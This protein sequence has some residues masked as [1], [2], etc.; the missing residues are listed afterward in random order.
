MSA[1]SDA[2][3]SNP[4]LRPPSIRC[5]SL[6]VA[7]RQCTARAMRG[8]DLCYPHAKNRRLVL[9]RGVNVT[10]PLF[11]DLD[12]IRVFGTQMIQG[13]LTKAID[14]RR[15]GKI[16]YACQII[17]NTM[18]R[19]ARLAAT[20]EQEKIADPVTEVSEGPD[21]DLGP[22]EDSRTQA[23]FGDIWS[24]D[25]YRFEQECER[26]GRPLPK[27]PADLPQSGWLNPEDID[28]V[29]RQR[30]TGQRLLLDGGYRDKILALHLE[31]DLRGELPPI[32]DR[33]CTFGADPTC[34]GPGPHGAAHEACNY[35]QQELDQ[36][37][38]LHPGVVL[39]P[40]HFKACAE[41][42]SAL[43]TMSDPPLSRVLGA[44]RRRR[45]LRHR[46]ITWTPPVESVNIANSRQSNPIPPITPY[47]GDP[48]RQKH[49]PRYPSSMP[50][51]VAAAL[52]IGRSFPNVEESTSWGAPALKVC[53]NLM[54]C[55]PTNKAAEPDSFLIRMD[56]AE[57]PA[58]LAEAPDLYYAPD[59]YLGYDAVLV[60]LAHCT[61]ELMHD[62]LAMAHRFVCRKPAP[63][64][65]KTHRSQSRQ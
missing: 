17:A 47:G 27:T 40:T 11:E 19:P 61:P 5:R 20:N 64:P 31:A 4:I 34:A 56:R 37:L 32:A 26:L 22:I 43:D 21:G 49:G 18:P 63:K 1:A 60:R 2:I 29:R 9:P 35:C 58:L 16:L 52:R 54:A 46:G 7:G 38:R 62:L 8:Q 6:T 57:R 45:A 48:H 33:R 55:V 10:L 42:P 14:S 65:G 36:Y 50:L 41:E 12:S 30:D 15:A 44:S 25:K 51:T 39:P 28:K 23:K 24:M 59:H 53:G 3:A 13:L